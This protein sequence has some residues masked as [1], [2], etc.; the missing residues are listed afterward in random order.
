M[1]FILKHKE[2]PYYLTWDL[3]EQSFEFYRDQIELEMKSN[4]LQSFIVT[5]TTRREEP[6]DN[7]KTKKKLT[8]KTVETNQEPLDLPEGQTTIQSV[9]ETKEKPKRVRKGP[10]TRKVVNNKTP[11]IQKKQLTKKSKG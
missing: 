7:T 10:R 5:S 9:E 11:R 8:R 2:L 3:D 6:V 1:A 4:G